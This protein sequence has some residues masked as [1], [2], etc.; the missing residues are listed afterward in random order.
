VG[1]DPNN[2]QEDGVPV[3]LANVDFT[4]VPAQEHYIRA[5][6]MWR[7]NGKGHLFRCRCM[8]MQVDAG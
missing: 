1:T 3:F 6:D 7:A 5:C 4:S 2:P 8:L